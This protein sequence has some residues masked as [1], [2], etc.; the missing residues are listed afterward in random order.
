MR[1]ADVCQWLGAVALEGSLKNTSAFLSAGL[2]CNTASAQPSG[3]N[4]GQGPHS[5]SGDSARRTRDPSAQTGAAAAVRPAIVAET[6]SSRI[7]KYLR[8]FIMTSSQGW[9]FA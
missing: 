9:T 3:M 8:D 2:P 6:T 7:E 1:S 4:C 5:S